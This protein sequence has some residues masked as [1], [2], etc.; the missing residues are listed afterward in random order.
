VGID[1]SG[2]LRRQARIAKHFD[3]RGAAAQPLVIYADHIKTPLA[4]S[5]KTA[6]ILA[7]DGRDQAALVP[8]NSRFCRLYV[9][10][11][12]RLHFDKTQNAIF[13]PNKIY[14]SP[15][16]RRAKVSSY[17]GIAKGSE[18]EV[19]RLFSLAPNAVMR[20]SFLWR[21][22]TIREPV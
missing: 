21:Q 4:R 13:P 14:F 5:G 22:G 18:V 19:S 3:V 2:I 15:A 17:H 16:T 7:G 20:G 6:P 11:G 8:V 1:E 12:S 9:V 10:C